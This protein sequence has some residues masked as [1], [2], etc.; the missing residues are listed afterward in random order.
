VPGRVIFPALPLP[1]LLPTANRTI[2]GTDKLPDAS[3]DF[4]PSFTIPACITGPRCLCLC[5]LLLLLL[6]LRR[7]GA[8]NGETTQNRF[9]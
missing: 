1:A 6:L 9:Q 7:H 4:N 3:Q 2:I 5:L 8:L